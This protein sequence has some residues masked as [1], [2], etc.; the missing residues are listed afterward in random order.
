[1]NTLGGGADRLRAALQPGSPELRYGRTWHLSQI[2]EE[3][4]FLHGRLGF[5]QQVGVDLWQDEAQDFEKAR[6][7][8]GVAAPFVIRM[9]D[10]V[11]VYQPRRQ[12]IRPESFAGAL[13][14][15]LRRSGKD[16]TWQI[17]SLAGERVPF[18]KWR[19]TVDIVTRLRFR[20]EPPGPPQSYSSTV[21]G[22]IAA[23]GPDLAALEWRAAAGLNTEAKLVQELLSQVEAGIGDMV[24]YGRCGNAS[25]AERRWNSVLGDESVMTEVEVSEDGGE[26]SRSSLLAQFEAIDI[27]E[28]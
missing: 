24:A 8:N 7:D 27:F 4:G 22:L 3:Q 15:I 1:M 13:R 11:L 23:V 12:G 20:L 5:G 25:N 2:H 14:A 28:R 17:E 9:V 16:E 10:M 19:A 6:V 26:V 21:A 18:E